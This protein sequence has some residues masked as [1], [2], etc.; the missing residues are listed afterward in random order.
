MFSKRK[1]SAVGLAVTLAMFA[2]GC[3]KKVPPP[4]P[5]PPPAATAPTTP[6]PAGAPVVASFTVEPTTIQ[7][8]QSATLRWEV[9]GNANSVSINNGIGA[10]QNTGNRRVSPTSSTTYTLTATGPGGEVTSS[11]T[12]TVVSTPP[13]PPPTAPQSTASLETRI[14]AD[15]QDVYFDYD[16]SDVRG[17]GQNV[18]TQDATAL[19]S[20]LA[21]FPNATIVLE[22]HCDERGSAE[23]NLGLGDRRATSA[24]EFLQGLGVPADRM[25][26]ISYG[27]ER[28]QCTEA[29]ESCYQKNRRVH[30]APG[31]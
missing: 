17:D 9:T 15:L 21:D 14:S 11:A 2:A 31:Q 18:L 5:P 16:K 7:S 26:T 24:K 20:I 27:K 4:P 22:G 13:P 10:V 1:L 8:G 30:F 3:K 6:P 28:P 29:N 25:K 12:V 19:K 23:Y